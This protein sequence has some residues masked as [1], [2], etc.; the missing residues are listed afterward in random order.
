MKPGLCGDGY[1]KIDRMMDWSVYIIQCTNDSLYTGITNNIQR[2]FSQHLNRRGAK[3]FRGHSP[4]R[5]VYVE[6]G[7]TRSS[8]SRREAAIKKHTRIGKLQLIL[9]GINEVQGQKLGGIQ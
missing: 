1:G 9:S 6:N 2:R 4:K 7:H 3:F 8:A 5:I